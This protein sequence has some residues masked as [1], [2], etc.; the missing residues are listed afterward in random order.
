MLVILDKCKMLK[1][2]VLISQLNSKARQIL[3]NKRHYA[4]QSTHFGF[5]Q[6]KTDE[7]Q[8][9]GIGIVKAK[10]LGQRLTTCFRIEVNEVFSNVARTY[11]LMNDTMS[12]G[13]HRI[14]KDQ[15]IHDLKPSVGMKLIDVAGGTGD[16][17][18]RYLHYLKNHNKHEYFSENTNRTNLVTVCDINSNMLEVGKERS[19]TL[20]YTNGTIKRKNMILINFGLLRQKVAY[21]EIKP[22][23]RIN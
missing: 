23:Q 11:D 18:F 22:N 8:G 12:F 5:K 21:T 7:K 17:A 2:T 3:Y 13:L 6:V 14:W 4:T 20:G 10:H 16:I 19:I 1:T 15:F 9:K